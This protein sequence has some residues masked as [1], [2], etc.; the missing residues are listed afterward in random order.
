MADIERP[1]GRVRTQDGVALHWRGWVPDEPSGLILFVHGM[2]EHSGRYERPAGYFSGRGLA[3]YGVDL[4]GHGLSDGPRGHADRFDD[5]LTDLGA[6]LALVRGLHPAMPCAVAGH[7]MGGLVAIRHALEH[8]GVVEGY[9]VTS[10]GLGAHPSFE[11]GAFKKALARLLSRVAPKAA[12]PS[13]LDA[14]GLSHDPAV[15]EAY[16]ADPLVGRKVTARWYAGI[17]AAIADTL[18]RAPDLKVP[19]LLMQ[20]GDD[21]IVDGQAVRRWAALA[22]PEVLEYVEWEGFYHE[23]YNEPDAP[24]VFRKA[25]AWLETRLGFALRAE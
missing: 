16:L 24:R 5:Y 18:G 21:R 25:A 4:R 6:A 10:P 22:P 17:T 1:S 8:P 11:P 3:C 19:M 12:I 15:V 23:L 2:G 13:N 20:A 9:V 14:S 7:S